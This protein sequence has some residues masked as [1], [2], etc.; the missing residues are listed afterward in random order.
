MPGRVDSGHGGAS[1]R[2]RA[3]ALLALVALCTAFNLTKAFH[4]DDTAYLEIA[5]AILADPLHPMRADVNWVGTARPIY[6]LNQPHLLF[7]PMAGLIAC[8][9]ASEV[10][11]HCLI[12]AFT[13][14]AVVFFYR[15]AGCLGCSYPLLLTVMFALGPAF[16]PSQNTMVDV[17][18]VAM[19]L[20]FFW[21]LLTAPED[22]PGPRHL[23]AVAVASAACLTK[24]TSLVLLPIFAIAAASRRQWRSL[25]LLAVP[26]ATLAAWSA[27]NVADFGKPH[28]FGR[29]VGGGGADVLGGNIVDWIAGLGAVAPFTIG[30]LAGVRRD[31]YRLWPALGVALAAVALVPAARMQSGASP[32]SV[33]L[34]VLF[35]GNGLL[36][37]VLVLGPIARRVG[38][39]P[40]GMLGI[41]YRNAVLLLW[42]AGAVGFCVAFAP[43]MA[44]RHVLLALPPVLLL[45]GRNARRAPPVPWVSVGTALTVTLGVLL[46]LSDYR[47]AA[48][49][50]RFATSIAETHA[51]SGTVRF[52]GHWGW[53]WYARQA[54][55]V[56]Y[57]VA[58]TQ[59][60]QGDR[61]V[62]PQGVNRQFRAEDYGALLVPI[63]ELVVPGGPLSWL[64]TMA[65][66]PS[67]GFY[68]YSF[69]TQVPPWFFSSMPLERFIVYRYEGRQE[70]S[71][72][73]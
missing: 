8:F 56:Q 47:A 40:R 16:L 48:V 17:P 68:S 11:L 32:Q 3:V 13:A 64:R 4:I 69:A 2:G 44:V 36:A 54:G 15:L 23:L 20:I 67:G 1:P 26:A 50:K 53:Q 55:L 71:H 14:L 46:A 52:A 25:F 28:L 18:V 30:F 59:F 34:W 5:Q 37:L 57:D 6:F 22:R 72:P 41:G 31:R 70:V 60:A 24:Y 65:Q 29:P 9:G 19:W 33:V 12:A 27:W 38:E 10:V 21:A 49:Y 51:G 39:R 7:Y 58:R 61:I 35:Y 66:S 73:R 42:L 63:E 43:F 62:V 45:L